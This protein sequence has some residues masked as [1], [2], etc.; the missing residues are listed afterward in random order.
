MPKPK[1][2]GARP[3]RPRRAAA[4]RRNSG[5]SDA[6]RAGF[7]HAAIELDLARVALSLAAH[8][9]ARGAYPDAL[10]ALVPEFAKALPADRA[11]GAALEYR[12]TEKGCILRSTGLKEGQDIAVELE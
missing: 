8:K 11:T 7:E 6:L 5:P 9:R 3:G 1:A 2:P 10:A 4:A 12:R